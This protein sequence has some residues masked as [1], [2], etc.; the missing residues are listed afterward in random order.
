MNLKALEK[1]VRALLRMTTVP[2]TRPPK[3]TKADLERKFVM[4]VD[5][6]GK[7]TIKDVR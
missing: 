4:R 6:G 3:P 5:R 1:A 2:P 7:P